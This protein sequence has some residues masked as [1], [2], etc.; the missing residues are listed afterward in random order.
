[1]DTMDSIG[2]MEEEVA[3]HEHEHVVRTK[4]FVEKLEV[5]YDEMLNTGMNYRKN[6]GRLLTDLKYA[7]GSL[8][9]SDVLYHILENDKTPLRK[10]WDTLLDARFSKHDV[11][12]KTMQYLNFVFDSSSSSLLH[13]PVHQFQP[14]AT[15]PPP[16]QQQHILQSPIQ[17]PPIQLHQQQSPI[18]YQYQQQ[19]QQQAYTSYTSTRSVSAHAVH[20]NRPSSTTHTNTPP[21]AYTRTYSYGT[22]APFQPHVHAADSRSVVQAASYQGSVSNSTSGRS[23]SFLLQGPSQQPLVNNYI[24]QQQVV[25]YTTPQ[26]PVVVQRE[27]IQ[28]VDKPIAIRQ[29]SLSS[30]PSLQTIQLKSLGASSSQQNLIS[31]RTGESESNKKR[32]DR[33]ISFPYLTNKMIG[34]DV[35]DE[36][37]DNDDVR[38]M[39]DEAKKDFKSHEGAKEI[40]LDG[41]VSIS[42]LNGMSNGSVVYCAGADVLLML[43]FKNSRLEYNGGVQRAAV[44]PVSVREWGGYV[45]VNSVSIRGWDMMI[46]DK[47]LQE[48]KRLKGKKLQVDGVERICVRSGEDKQ[49]VWMSEDKHLSMLDMKDM[50]FMQLQDFWMYKH[51]PVRI[52]AVVACRRGDRVV[53]VGVT[54]PSSASTPSVT[55]SSSKYTMHV[56]R[57]KHQTTIHELEIRGNIRGIEASYDEQEVVVACDDEHHMMIYVSSI[58]DVHMKM[59]W[60]HMGRIASIKR[61]ADGDIFFI[62]SH[63]ALHVLFYHLHIFYLVSSTP[64]LSTSPPPTDIF[65]NTSHN[66]LFLAHNTSSI[67]IISFRPQP[68]VLHNL[69][70]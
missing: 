66:L 48:V 34:S 31:S 6:I 35:T 2:W 15:H 12:R 5:W 54:S 9:A 24:P 57:K 28:V 47:K 26:Q 43:V 37:I 61:H 7:I 62:A 59:L 3:K 41:S 25:P 39:L 14:I 53:G 65:F 68:L 45:L 49:V 22:P 19:Q 20:Y 42:K 11:E 51:M 38:E 16:I 55:T 4:R 36:K 30:S 29:D 46:M 60:K 52:V 63:H 21:Q 69:A 67:T 50:K 10:Q 8:P 17:H 23:V 32:Y 44:T 13:A 64:L 40:R 33:S 18:L 70:L 56:W 27:V 1:M 58:D